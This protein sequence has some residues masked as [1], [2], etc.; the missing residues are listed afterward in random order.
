MFCLRA[1]TK[2]AD[3]EEAY[4]SLFVPALSYRGREDA[5]PLGTVYIC[6]VPPLP[7]A[8]EKRY[9]LAAWPR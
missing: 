8:I 3:A 1:T 4:D 5:M 2:E 6:F 7:P 9:I